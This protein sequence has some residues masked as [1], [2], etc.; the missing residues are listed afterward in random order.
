MTATQMTTTSESNYKAR[1]CRV[2]HKYIRAG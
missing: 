1:V 2:C